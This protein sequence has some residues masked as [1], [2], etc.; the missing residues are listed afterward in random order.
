[1]KQAASSAGFLFDLH[2]NSED[3]DDMFLRNVRS[4]STDYTA[5]YPRK[6]LIITTAV[7]TSDPT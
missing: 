3:G 2:F 6:Q 1:M 5:L 4:F 7:R